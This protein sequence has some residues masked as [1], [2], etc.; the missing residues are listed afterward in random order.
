[1]NCKLNV[2]KHISRIQDNV[3]IVS[4]TTKIVVVVVVMGFNMG[5][6]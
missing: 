1:M 4:S 6:L 2:L 3:I 5:G